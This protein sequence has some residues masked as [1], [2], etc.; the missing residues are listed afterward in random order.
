MTVPQYQAPYREN[1]IVLGE[2]VK[3]GDP[4]DINKVIAEILKKPD[5]SPQDVV[6]NK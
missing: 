6:G 5:Q 4:N 2:A 3:S 1:S